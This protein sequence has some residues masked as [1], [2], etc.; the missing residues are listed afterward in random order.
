MAEGDA[1][2]VDMMKVLLR[3]VKTND[4]TVTEKNKKD[5]EIEE[6]INQ[7]KLINENLDKDSKESEETREV[8]IKELM[9]AFEEKGFSIKEQREILKE[10]HE[11]VYS[12][13]ECLKTL[14]VQ[15]MNS[16]FD[17]FSSAKSIGKA[18]LS[19][20]MD[21]N[22]LKSI[23]QDITAKISGLFSAIS[24]V[25]SSIIDFIKNPIDYLKSF[26]SY[27]IEGTVSLV[28]VGL[29]KL[30]NFI[31]KSAIKPVLEGLYKLAVRVTA[32]AIDIGAMI[33]RMVIG[34][35]SWIGM[36]VIPAL[37]TILGFI[38]FEIIPTLFVILGQMVFYFVSTVIPFL[39][40]VVT[41]IASLSVALLPVIGISLLIAAFV[42][43]LLYF[44]IKMWDYIKDWVGNF[45]D[46]YLRG[47]NWEKLKED[48]YILKTYITD[49]VWPAIQGIWNY[50]KD[51]WNKYLLP[52]IEWVTDTLKQQWNDYLLP[53]A[54]W[55]VDSLKDQW[56]RPDSLFNFVLGQLK[57]IMPYLVTS[58]KWIAT[59]FM[60]AAEYW[61]GSKKKEAERNDWNQTNTVN[62]AAAAQAQQYR[63]KTI[64]VKGFNAHANGGIVTKPEFAMIGEGGDNEAVIPL[65]KKGM[66]FI[67]NA[68]ALDDL[69]IQQIIKDSTLNKKQISIETMVSQLK[70]DNKELRDDMKFGFKKIG[71]EIKHSTE[72][73]AVLI[74]PE[75]LEFEFEEFEGMTL[76][77]IQKLLK[78]S[79]VES[80]KKLD[81]LINLINTLQNNTKVDPLV[82]PGTSVKDPFQSFLEAVSTGILGVRN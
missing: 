40:S 37:G 30:G 29:Q 49:T 18:I 80:N 55:L 10:I 48:F 27:I 71:A 47:M 46:K 57:M 65:N 79:G 39:V 20:I 1:L 33:F 31:W 35:I 61:F 60:E 62:D 5:E 19:G 8:L 64:N 59:Q 69:A 36:T 11:D 82:N 21:S 24:K 53:A 32:I 3:K 43:V 26:A 70:V 66:E 34:F 42:V 78:E 45:Y 50:I 76:E 12:N 25:G 81:A 72:T 14:N 41:A 56:E 63:M 22:I 52:A 7:L 9:E 28:A 73:L 15:G 4:T 68:F 13:M 58:V 75:T 54:M 74:K 77:D 51:V 16:F 23:T 38:L 44:V 67:R 6:I 2:S 17:M